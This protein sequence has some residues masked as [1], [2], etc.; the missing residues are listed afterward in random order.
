[1]RD[2]GGVL[3]SV[4]KWVIKSFSGFLILRVVIIIIVFYCN[5]FG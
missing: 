2:R 1:M 5:R 4:F 3:G